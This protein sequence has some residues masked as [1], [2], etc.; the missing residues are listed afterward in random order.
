METEDERARLENDATTK[1]LRLVMETEEERKARLVKMVA[2]TQLRLTWKQ[3][4]K[5][6]IW[7]GLR[8]EFSKISSNVLAR[9]VMGTIFLVYTRKMVPIMGRASS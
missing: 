9:P 8:L 7:I 5:E 6:E 4:M 3:R 1:R 2:P